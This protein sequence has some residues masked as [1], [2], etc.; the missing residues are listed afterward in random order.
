[1]KEKIQALKEKL[2]QNRALRCGAV[3]A[4]LT[5]AVAALILLIGAGAD[6]LESR[7]ALQ[8]DF[9]FN[10]ITTQSEITDAVLSQLDKDVRIYAVVPE[11]G[12]D[13]ALLSLLERYGAKS[14]R[15]QWT[16]E[17]LLK[18]PV[19]QN[20]FADLS[21]ERQVTDDCLIVACPQ[22]GRARILNENDYY[23]YSYNMDTGSFD[24]AY[25]TYEKS[26]TEA[27]LYVS[28]DEIPLIQVLSGHGELTQSEVA[29]MED[30]LVTANYAIKRVNLSAGDTLDKDSPLMIL[31]PRY[32][33]SEAELTAL[34]AFAAQGGSFFVAVQYADPIDLSRFNA[35]FRA[36][37]IEMLPGL[38]IAKEGD[39]GSYYA[40]QPVY[41]MPYM[42]ESDVTAPLLSA[43]KDIL[44]LGGARAFQLTAAAPEGVQRTP[45]LLT[46]EAYIRA[47]S[48]GSDD[49]SL[50]PGDQEG[51][52]PVAVWSDRMS[53]E[54]QVS[55]LFM[56]GNVSMFVD[57]WVQNSTDANAFLLQMLRSLR[58]QDP[59][60]LNILPKTALRQGLTLGSVTPAVIAAVMLPL[61]VLLAAALV[62]WPRK[63][64]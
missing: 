57:Y 20:Q 3:S 36:Y 28:Q 51:V 38:V 61:L 39:T 14:S 4:V 1:M 8:A 63:N 11:D 21:G 15:I 18:N 25:F 30:T 41:L 2:K 53:E 23:V 16:R 7:F 55:R 54:G 40:D 13:V 64:L 35:L 5:A 37:G 10:G 24:E 44:L 60:N 46:G 22:T 29:A 27:V 17:S 12:G 34:E 42:Q 33:L 45:V 48:D 62:L 6:A 26:L 50:Q 31:S 19:L 58:G 59:V 43:G 56:V 47:F 52:F 49:I 9:S 32:D